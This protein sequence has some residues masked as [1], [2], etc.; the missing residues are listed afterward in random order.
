[1]ALDSLRKTAETRPARFASINTAECVAMKRFLSGAAF[2]LVVLLTLTP[3]TYGQR[4]KKG[5]PTVRSVSG[6]VTDAGGGP[7]TGAVVQLKNTKTLQIRSFIT[8]DEGQYYFQGLNP[9]VDF[10]VH[11]ESKDAASSTHTLSSFNTDKEA[12]INLKMK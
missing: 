11:A 12:V 10:E 3:A 1:M 5:Q 9:D 6:T 7:V 8:K 4:T 2:F